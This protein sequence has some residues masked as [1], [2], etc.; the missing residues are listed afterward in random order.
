MLT[1]KCPRRVQLRIEGKAKNEAPSAL[2]RGVLIGEVLRQVHE[3]G[4]WE[5]DE[6]TMQAMTAAC[7]AKVRRQMAEENRMLTDAVETNMPEMRE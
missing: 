2:F 5:N 1:D 3:I 6:S 4:V 7:E